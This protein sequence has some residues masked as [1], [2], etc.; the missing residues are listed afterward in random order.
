[1]RNLNQILFL[2][3]ALFCISCNTATQSDLLFETLSG[4]I[5]K[6]ITVE[7][8]HILPMILSQYLY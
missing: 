7:G 8:N 1:M 2:L 6:P 4:T 5:T 3:V